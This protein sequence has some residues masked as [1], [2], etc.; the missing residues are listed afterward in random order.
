VTD[1]D[2]TVLAERQYEALKGPHRKAMDEF[3]R[4]LRQL[5]CAAINGRRGYRLSG[6]APVNRLCD[7]HLHGEDRVIVAFEPPKVAVI[8]MIGPHRTGHPRD[9]YVN[10]WQAC[11]LSEPPANEITKPPCCAGD[12]GAPLLPAAEIIEIVERCRRLARTLT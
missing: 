3:L 7:R 11:G 6:E 1:I 4:E 10:L 12:G 2:F 8:L 9:V 5:G